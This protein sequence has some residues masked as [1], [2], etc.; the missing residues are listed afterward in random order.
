M[1]TTPVDGKSSAK[2]VQSEGVV[3]FYSKPRFDHFLVSD[4]SKDY[5]LFR[6][7]V[8]LF[9]ETN[10][11]PEDKRCKIFLS[12]I[13]ECVYGLIHDRKLSHCQRYSR[14]LIAITWPWQIKEPKDT[15]STRSGRKVEN[16]WR[17]SLP[18]SVRVQQDVISVTGRKR[19]WL[20]FQLRPK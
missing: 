16:H 19:R 2:P 14:F 5:I 1:T 10:E 9:F 8:E 17:N 7:R 6:E 11:V 18:E 3:S 4:K 13:S 15:N 12:S 20:Q